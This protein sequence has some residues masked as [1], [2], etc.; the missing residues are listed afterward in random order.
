MDTVQIT[1]IRLRDRKI[2]SIKLVRNFLTTTNGGGTLTLRDAKDLVDNFERGIPFPKMW[3]ILPLNNDFKA[4]FIYD[5]DPPLKLFRV[6]AILDLAGT[7]EEYE[8]VILS[9]TAEQ[10]RV[11]TLDKMVADHGVPARVSGIDEITSFKNNTILA[12]FPV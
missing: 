7:A 10:A 6:N 8:V 11:V 5:E 9:T 1:D 4:Q 2:Q 12:C 3:A